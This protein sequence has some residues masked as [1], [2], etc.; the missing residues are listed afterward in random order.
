MVSIIMIR[1]FDL[2]SMP[3]A[4]LISI[5]LFSNPGFVRRFFSHHF[6]NVLLVFAGKTRSLKELCRLTIRR[7]CSNSQLQRL[8]SHELLNRP[9]FNY[10]L[11][12]RTQSRFE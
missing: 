5:R 3:F 4:L 6:R 8:A 10:I 7:H 9:L 1:N 11:F 2:L 12:N